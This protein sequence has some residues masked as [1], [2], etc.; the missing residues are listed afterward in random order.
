VL[1]EPLGTY[2]GDF[3]NGDKHGDGYYKS[4]NGTKYRG[5]YA[6]N[7]RNGKGVVYN[8]DDTIAYE[9]EIKNG[10]PHGKGKVRNGDSYVEATWNEGIDASLI[11]E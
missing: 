9:G 10:L 4:K 11:M 8:S 1:I 3:L 2:E 5:Q 6:N 7:E